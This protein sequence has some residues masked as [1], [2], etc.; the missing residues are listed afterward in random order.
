LIADDLFPEGIIP[1]YHDKIWSFNGKLGINLTELKNSKI[2]I[3]LRFGALVS[4][5]H[6]N[7]FVNS[8]WKKNSF[9]MP[10]QKIDNQ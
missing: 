1:G 10:T 2:P 9:R 3:N 7:R 4:Q 5:D 8:F 6:G